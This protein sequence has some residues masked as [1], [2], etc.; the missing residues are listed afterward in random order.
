[1]YANSSPSRTVVEERVGAGGGRGGVGGGGG[2]L[3]CFRY[4]QGL[5]SGEYTLKSSQSH[6][7][8]L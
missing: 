6:H 1:M 7:E 4:Q 3:T 5:K 2:G 8:H